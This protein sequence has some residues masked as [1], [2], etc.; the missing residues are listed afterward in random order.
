MKTVPFALLGPW[1]FTAGWP[2]SFRWL[3]AAS[4]SPGMKAIRRTS[5]GPACRNGW[6]KWFL[7]PMQ[8][9]VSTCGVWYPDLMKPRLGCPLWPSPIL[10]A[11][12]ISWRLP[13]GAPQE[14]LFISTCGMCL[15]C[16]TMALTLRQWL[17]SRLFPPSQSLS[18]KNLKPNEPAFLLVP[19]C[20][21]KPQY[22]N[23]CLINILTLTHIKSQP[24][25]LLHWAPSSCSVG[26]IL[27]LWA[28][29]EE[30]TVHVQAYT[31]FCLYR[32]RCAHCTPSS[33]AA[34]IFV[35]GRNS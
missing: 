12:M 28:L 17:L 13:A 15:A 8:G 22:I 35:W 25:F 9:R 1:E 7:Q 14:L 6:Q 16:G 18:H 10:G 32:R 20:T 2:T 3:V 4:S 21:H 26:G 24:A 31:A 33:C 30:V 34:V 29:T 5:D 11:S 19:L 27:F 23:L